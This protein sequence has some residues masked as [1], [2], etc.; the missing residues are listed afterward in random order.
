M[1]G[2]LVDNRGLYPVQE[3]SVMFYNGVLFFFNSKI[4]VLV[5]QFFNCWVLLSLKIKWEQALVNFVLWIKKD[6]SRIKIKD[7]DSI[8]IF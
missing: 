5:N 3:I 2:I 8:N 4:L 1:I 7:I 6:F